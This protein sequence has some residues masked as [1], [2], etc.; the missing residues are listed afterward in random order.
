M[1][2]FLRNDLYEVDLNGEF[3]GA[4]SVE[5]LREVFTGYVYGSKLQGKYAIT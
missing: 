5:K 3:L 4:L 1:M 2:N